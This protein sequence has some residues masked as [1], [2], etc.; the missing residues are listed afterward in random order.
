MFPVCLGVVQSIFVHLTCNQPAL[1]GL[2]PCWVIRSDLPWQDS[3]D[4]QKAFVKKS[5]EKPAPAAC[6]HKHLPCKAAMG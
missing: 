2:L 1:C 3:R 6:F 5:A 4:K